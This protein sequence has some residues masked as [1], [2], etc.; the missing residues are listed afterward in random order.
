MPSSGLSVG[1]QTREGDQPSV[2]K[3]RLS[4]CTRQRPQMKPS[5]QSVQRCDAWPGGTHRP[6]PLLLGP[7][8]PAEPRQW[9]SSCG[10]LLRSVGAIPGS[11]DWNICLAWNTE[12]HPLSGEWPDNW[13]ARTY[14]PP[15][16]AS[17][18][19]GAPGHAS[20]C[21]GAVG[22]REAPRASRPLGLIGLVGSHR[23]FRGKETD[24]CGLGPNRRLRQS[25]NAC[26]TSRWLR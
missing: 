12:G 14:H 8:T 7:Q 22:G 19:P 23:E 10:L 5:A 18:R 15:T 2:C 17:A 20:R 24:P 9:G 6:R 13:R 4:T 11:P 1:Q 25:T 26:W 16:G 21:R 3:C